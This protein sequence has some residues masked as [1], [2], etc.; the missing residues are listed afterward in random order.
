L[1]TPPNATTFLFS[2]R[3]HDLHSTLCQRSH[4]IH[5]NPILSGESYHHKIA[6]GINKMTFQNSTEL[7]G[8][9]EYAIESASNTPRESS[10]NFTMLSARPDSLESGEE[11]RD[12]LGGSLLHHLDGISEDAAT[13]HSPRTAHSLNTS[14]SRSG[15]SPRIPQ[16]AQ[17]GRSCSPSSQRGGMEGAELRVDYR[18]RSHSP[19]QEYTHDHEV[20]HAQTS[21]FPSQQS[22]YI[23]DSVAALCLSDNS[24]NVVVSSPPTIKMR[25]YTM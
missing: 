13:K 3:K 1:F 4:Q 14:T 16:L 11:I 20:S 17:Q 6:E 25:T 7:L 24:A 15:Q 19:L 9:L 8:D 2:I 12:S 10:F 5:E 21:G 22:K 23:N 18:S